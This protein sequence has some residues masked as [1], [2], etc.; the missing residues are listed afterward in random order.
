[1]I[2]ESDLFNTGFLNDKPQQLPVVEIS[3][4]KAKFERLADLLRKRQQMESDALYAEQVTH[5]HCCAS[6]I[7]YVK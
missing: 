1:M 5:F 3:D 4:V 7:A 6:L 2:R